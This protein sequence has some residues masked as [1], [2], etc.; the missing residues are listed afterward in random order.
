MLKKALE[1]LEIFALN[2]YDAYIVGGYVRDYLLGIESADIDICTN[3]KPKDII[4]LFKTSSYKEINYGSVKILYKNV[5][6]DITTFRTCVFQF[7]VFSNLLKCQYTYC[8]HKHTQGQQ[9][10]Y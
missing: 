1:V 2:G 6:F 9:Y 5:R 10:T 7:A 3:A 8:R 4:D